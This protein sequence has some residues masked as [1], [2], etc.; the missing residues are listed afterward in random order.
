MKP[1]QP[2]HDNAEADQKKPHT[3]DKLRNDNAR[4]KDHDQ[5]DVPRGTGR[6]DPERDYPDPSGKREHDNGG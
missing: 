1:E 5:P 4:W 2:T 3:A 6:R